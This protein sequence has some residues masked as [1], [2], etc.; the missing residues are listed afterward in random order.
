MHIV[1][2]LT[3]SVTDSQEGLCAMELVRLMK[4]CWKCNLYRG[5]RK[6]ILS[7]DK[8]S[9]ERLKSPEDNSIKMDLM[10]SGC[11]VILMN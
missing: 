1:N 6:C 2:V 10:E 5:N 9:L 11:E 7:F 8:K 4:L 3:S